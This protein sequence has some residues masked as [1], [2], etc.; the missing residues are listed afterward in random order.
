[1]H[2]EVQTL[3]FTLIVCGII[4]FIMRVRELLGRDIFIDLILG[5]YRRPVSEDRVFIFIDLVG[6]TS[7]P[8]PMAI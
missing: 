1:M 7:L 5:R 6:S 8:K 4:V 2:A 3:I